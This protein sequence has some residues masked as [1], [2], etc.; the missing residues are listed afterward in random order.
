MNVCMPTEARRELQK[1]SQLKL[2][3]ANS[4][5]LEDQEE[6][7]LI[8]KLLSL[9]LFIALFSFSSIKKPTLKQEKFCQN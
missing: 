2:K 7:N 8:L 3:K 1:P 4:G 9:K 6:G 5:P